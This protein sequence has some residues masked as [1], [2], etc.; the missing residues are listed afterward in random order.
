[1]KEKLELLERQYVEE[2][3]RISRANIKKD[4]NLK[5]V[6][7]WNLSLNDKGSRLMGFPASLNGSIESVT[8]PTRK[9]NIS[10]VS[11]SLPLG[12][13]TA[14]LPWM[15]KYSNGIPE[16]DGLASISINLMG[17]KPTTNAK[18]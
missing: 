17:N 15:L 5:L 8:T 1:M 14:S 16:L 9:Y 11:N 7:H 13:L 12:K 2:M 6:L 10:F 4:M 18:I 3:V